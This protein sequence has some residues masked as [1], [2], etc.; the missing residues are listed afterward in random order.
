[1]AVISFIFILAQ[2]R[3]YTYLVK[4]KT[5][6]SQSIHEPTFEIENGQSQPGQP[7]SK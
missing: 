7:R 6:D 2:I 3:S 5:E 1:V 4:S